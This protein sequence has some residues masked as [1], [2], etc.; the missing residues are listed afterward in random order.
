MVNNVEQLVDMERLTL[1]SGDINTCLDRKPNNL[2]TTVLQDL[3]FRQLVT[4]PTHIAGGRIDHAYLRDSKSSLSTAT[5]THHS[6]YYSDHDGLCL[7]F[8]LK[9]YSMALHLSEYLI[10]VCYRVPISNKMLSRT[11]FGLT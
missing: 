8:T 4:N 5:L 2:L 10:L 1:I 11:K 7:A 6:P 3:G 9:V